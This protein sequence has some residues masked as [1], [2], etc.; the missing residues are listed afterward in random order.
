M[1]LM[2]NLYALDSHLSVP[3][4]PI[5]QGRYVQGDIR[6]NCGTTLVICMIF[7]FIEKNCTYVISIRIFIHH[8]NLFYWLN[9][10][11]DIYKNILNKSINDDSNFF[12]NLNKYIATLLQN[13]K[14][15]NKTLPACRCRPDFFLT[16][17]NR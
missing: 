16:L 13:N 5:A 8:P 6:R 12:K 1:K 15:N 10:L 14:H 11:K 7:P 4:A 9:P 17:S 3:L 2:S